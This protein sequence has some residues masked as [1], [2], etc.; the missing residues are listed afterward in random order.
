MVEE[1]TIRRNAKKEIRAFV[2]NPGQLFNYSVGLHEFGD[3]LLQF[4]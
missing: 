2:K 1:G 4:S 3:F